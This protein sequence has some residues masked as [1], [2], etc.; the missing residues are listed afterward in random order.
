MQPLK[1][2]LGGLLL[3]ASSTAVH[4]DALRDQAN[5]IFKPIPEQTTGLDAAQVELGRQLFF[6]PRLSASHVISCNTCHNIGTGGADNVPASSG[7]AWQKGARNSPTVFNAVFNVAQFWDGR[8]KDLEEQAKGPVQ[9]PVEMHN[10][11][12]NVEA[13]LKSMPEYVAA[14]EKAFPGDKQAVSFDNM[15]RALQAFESTLITPDSRF[16]QYLKGDDK[17]LDAKEKKGLQ[18]FMSAGCI[19][20]HNGVNLGGQAYFPFG[21]VKK[22]D[23]SILPSGDKGRFAVTKTQNDEYVFRAAPLRNV[24]LTAPYFHSGQVW[25]LE[26][27]VTI[28]GTAQLG[29]QLDAGEVGDIVAFLKTVTGKQPQVEYP[30]L[31][32]STASTP[33]PVD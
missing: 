26:E 1:L 6:E 24:A 31:P 4:A 18:A 28:M 8:A 2:A 23:A 21:L 25:D 33:R 11:P 29:K 9:N 17:A 16:D 14:F 12:K 19:S 7:H 27:A 15:A 22:P 32:P 10:T 30:L 5:A 3:A 13:T 20:C